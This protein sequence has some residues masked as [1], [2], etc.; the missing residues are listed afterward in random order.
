MELSE[1]TDAIIEISNEACE[2]LL[3]Y[4]IISPEKQKELR[5]LARER[6]IHSTAAFFVVAKVVENEYKRQSM[7]PEGVH[8]S[9]T[10]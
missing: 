5:H 10:V 9:E 8:F 2:D 6:G 1:I 7:T 4:G 3:V